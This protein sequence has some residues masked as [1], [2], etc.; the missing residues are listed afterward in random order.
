MT[1]AWFTIEDLGVM[2]RRHRPDDSVTR[3][4]AR[5]IRTD[6]IIVDDIGL[7]PVSRGRRRRLLPARRRRL[8]TPQPRGQLEPAPIRLRRDHAQDPGHR[9]RRPAPAP[10]PRRRH[11]R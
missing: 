9:D 7:L 6:L 8:R 10:R 11:P 3:A 1:V 2:V 5:L 4:M